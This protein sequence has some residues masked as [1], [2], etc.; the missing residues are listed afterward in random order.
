M[1]LISSG[2]DKHWFEV[3]AGDRNDKTC[4][5]TGWQGEEKVTTGFFYF[6]IGMGWGSDDDFTIRNDWG[7]IIC[8]GDQSL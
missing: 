8:M 3:Y 2:G 4:W 5:W 1:E 7:G 6:F